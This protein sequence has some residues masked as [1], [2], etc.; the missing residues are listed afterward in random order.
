MFECVD[1]DQEPFFGSH[2]IAGPCSFS[3]QNCQMPNCKIAKMKW[4][5]FRPCQSNSVHTVIITYYIASQSDTEIEIMPMI[6][7]I[8]W[9]PGQPFCHS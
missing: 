6:V 5:P 4:L 9:L 2:P 8:L 3:V 7:S 1:G